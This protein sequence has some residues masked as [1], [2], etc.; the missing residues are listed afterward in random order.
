MKN[1]GWPRKRPGGLAELQ[2][3][4]DAELAFQQARMDSPLDRF[5]GRLGR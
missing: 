2:A 1:D 3:R 4:R 5:R